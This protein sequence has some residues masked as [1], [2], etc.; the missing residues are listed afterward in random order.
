MLSNEEGR[1]RYNKDSNSIY[2]FSAP[3]GP[4]LNVEVNVNENSLIVQWQVGYFCD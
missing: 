3:S 1:K 4:P 2:D